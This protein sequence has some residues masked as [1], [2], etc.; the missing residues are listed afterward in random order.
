MQS[1]PEAGDLVFFSRDGLFPTH[2][3]IMDSADSYIHSPGKDGTVVTVEHLAIRSIK[4]RTDNRRQFYTFNPIGFKAP[5]LPLES[6]SLRY[7]QR[8]A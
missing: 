7:H 1:I 4:K 3:G 5:T 8:P 2:V 6:T